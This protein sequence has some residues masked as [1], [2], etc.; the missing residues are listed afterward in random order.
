VLNQDTLSRVKLINTKEDFFLITFVL[1]SILSFSLSYHYQKYLEL[2]QFSWHTIDATVVSQ[3]KITTL[4]K[5][6]TLF[7]LKTSDFSFTTS[8]QKEFKPLAGRDVELTILTDNIHFL[9]YLKGFYTPSRF[10]ALKRERS[11]RFKLLQ[12]IH[13]QHTDSM[14]GNLYGALFL[15]EPIEKRVRE[16]L[17]LLGVNHLAAI[18]ESVNITV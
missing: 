1:L 14:M 12:A 3:R 8:S 5:S 4:N 10:E 16:K 11:L 15:V 9:E 2:K 13:K 17:T 7:K 6:Y 18:S